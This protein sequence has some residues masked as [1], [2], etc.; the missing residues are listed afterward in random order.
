[1]HHHGPALTACTGRAHLAGQSA[2]RLRPPDR[3]GALVQGGRRPRRLRHHR[4]GLDAGRGGHQLRLCPGEL[5]RAHKGCRRPRVCAA[6]LA[7][8]PK[9]PVDTSGPRLGRR[10]AAADSRHPAPPEP[11][12]SSRGHHTE[13]VRA[14]RAAIDHLSPAQRKRAVPTARA[15][16]ARGVRRRSAPS[17][18][19]TATA[20][21]SLFASSDS[22]RTSPFSFTRTTLARGSKRHIR[23]V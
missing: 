23:P 16:H 1:M 8:A 22:I 10:A 6:R 9:P 5:H 19:P 18:P 12:S 21:R 3:R 7:C 4:P 15:V 11:S 14:D 13:E 17:P 2:L 20:I